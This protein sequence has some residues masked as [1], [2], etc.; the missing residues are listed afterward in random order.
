MAELVE[1]V[2]VLVRPREEW[3]EV[4]G[5]LRVCSGRWRWPIIRVSFVRF[6]RPWAVCVPSLLGEGGK[7]IMV[8]FLF[9]CRVSS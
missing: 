6:F 4:E 9:G 8:S 3:R 2:G 7:K 5:L 1:A